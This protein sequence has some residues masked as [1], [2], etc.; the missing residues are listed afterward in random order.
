MKNVCRAL[1]WKLQLSAMA[2][3]LISCSLTGEELRTGRPVVQRDHSSETTM[4][5]AIADR[6]PGADIL[7]EAEFA[8]AIVGRVFRYREVGSGIVVERPNEVFAEGGQYRVHWLR[9]ISR[10]TYSIGRGT[11]M[12]ECTGCQRTFLG[13]GRTRV[14]FRH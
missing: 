7:D 3:A 9:T 13:L 8:E 11:V 6:F 10:G 2:A 4:S 14:F 12:I 1:R 5:P